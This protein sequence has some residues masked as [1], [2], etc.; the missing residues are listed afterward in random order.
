[1]FDES[2]SFTVSAFDRMSLAFYRT[3]PTSRAVQ[4]RTVCPKEPGSGKEINDSFIISDP[5]LAIYCKMKNI[6]VVTFEDFNAR[7]G[8]LFSVEMD[9][10]EYIDLYAKSYFTLSLEGVVPDQPVT[11]YTLIGEITVLDDLVNIPNVVTKTFPL[12]T[13]LLQTARKYLC[14]DET[15]TITPTAIR[16]GLKQYFYSEYA[17]YAGTATVINDLKQVATDCVFVT[18]DVQLGI[19]SRP[20][21]L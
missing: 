10:E 17:T 20:T 7:Y 3:V 14:V 16:C 13:P 8:N 21:T 1:M 18:A 9:E 11:E 12:P 4:L 19:I 2:L 5:S 15:E 6:N